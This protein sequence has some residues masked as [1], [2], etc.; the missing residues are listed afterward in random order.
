MHNTIRST[1]L[2]S[3]LLF[4]L[5][6]PASNCG[7][8]TEIIIEELECPALEGFAGGVYFFTVDV[9]GIADGC[10][11][12]TF[13]DLIDQGPYGPVTL[14][15]SST[16]PQ[17]ITITLPLVGDVTGT[18]YVDGGV[19]RLGVE[20]PI[21]VV[22]IILPV[23]GPVNVTARVSGTLCPISATRVDAVFTINVVDIDPDVPLITTPCTVG[24]PGTLQ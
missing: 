12:G 6:L 24:V 18:L 3:I 9:G 21:Q 23:F 8:E 16:L 11:D 15:A 10:A 2:R 4:A 17:D 1:W 20:D 22:G 5:V 13:N 7:D 19:M 14:P